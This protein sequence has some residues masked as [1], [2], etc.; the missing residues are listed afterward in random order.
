MFLC[1]QL[2]D[3]SLFHWHSSFNFDKRE[4]CKIRGKFGEVFFQEDLSDIL[5]DLV[6]RP[7]SLSVVREEIEKTIRW[8]EPPGKYM[9]AEALFDILQNADGTISVPYSRFWHLVR[10]HW[11][12]FL[13]SSSLPSSRISKVSGR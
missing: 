9:C 4:I 2:T 3:F 10:I 6:I 7:R 8:K 11:T 13:L 5:L 12:S 1:I